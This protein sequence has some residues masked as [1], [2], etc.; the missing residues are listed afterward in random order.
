METGGVGVGVGV[1][2]GE[3]LVVAGKV[4]GVGVAEGVVV[5]EVGERDVVGVDVG[6]GAEEGKNVGDFE[7]AG[8]GLI[9]GDP[10]CAK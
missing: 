10:F 6:E 5:D 3:G 2:V 4:V 9:L 8:V 7:G 1:G